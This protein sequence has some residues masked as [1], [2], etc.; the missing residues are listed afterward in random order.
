MATQCACRLCGVGLTE[1]FV[2]LGMSPTVRELRRRRCARPAGGVLTHYMYASARRASSCSC[3]HTYRVRRDLLR[4]RLLLVVLGFLGGACQTIRGLRRRATRPHREEPCHRSREQ[5]RIPATAF[6]GQW[7][8]HPRHRAG[9]NVAEV[10]ESRGIPTV[11]EF[12]GSTTGDGIAGRYGRADLVVANNV[13]PHVPDIR[14]FAAG[15]RALVKDTGLVTLEF[16]T[17]FVFCNVVSS[18]PSITNIT[19]TCLY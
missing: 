11:V 15:L 9:Q 18:T 19:R 8:T 4:L 13:F 7:R 12:L 17:C 14:D 6:Q 16:P 10:A 3:R 2:D 5:R 1:T